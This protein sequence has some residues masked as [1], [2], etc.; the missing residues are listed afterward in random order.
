MLHKIK[1][2]PAS[3]LGGRLSILIT[4][5]S[6]LSLLLIQNSVLAVWEPPI[7]GP[8]IGSSG[9]F[10][11]SPL[12]IDLDIDS[13]DIKSDHNL[14]TNFSLSPNSETFGLQISGGVAGL[15]GTG[16]LLGIHGR[17]NMDISLGLGFTGI[18]VAMIG[19][20]TTIGTFFAAFLFGGLVNGGYVMQVM[21]GVPLSI[22]YASQAII[23]LFFLCSALLAKYRII[24]VTKND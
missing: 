6:I 11:S 13:F 10:L 7:E 1:S 17:L 14:R 18:I 4:I 22:V 2:W 21:T 19:G 3:R 15:A 20:L 16:E 8:P 5:V 24:K 23:L 9:S 12:T